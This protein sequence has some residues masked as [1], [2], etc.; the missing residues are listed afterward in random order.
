MT[1]R[2]PNIT[3]SSNKSRKKAAAPKTPYN[4]QGKLNNIWV[5]ENG[6]SHATFIVDP[7]GTGTYCHISITFPGDPTKYH[8]GFEVRN[9]RHRAMGKHFWTT[10]YIHDYKFTPAI[11]RELQILYRELCEREEVSRSRSIELISRSR[12]NSRDK[13]DNRDRRDRIGTLRKQPYRN[14]NRG[15]SRS[16]SRSR[17]SRYSRGGFLNNRIPCKYKR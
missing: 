12:N 9:N 1:S 7:K 13:R 2:K 3:R 16:R 4:K 10:P 17:N 8:Y 14:R 5:K 15:R 6:N 11:K